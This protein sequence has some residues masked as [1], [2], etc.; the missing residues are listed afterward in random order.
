MQALRCDLCN[1][2]LVMDAS[3]E[4]A[5]CEYCGTKYLTDRLRAKIQEIKGTVKVEGPVE[6]VSG[7]AE[8]ERQFEKADAFLRLDDVTHAYQLLQE[9]EKN[10]PDDV[11]TWELYFKIWAK[12]PSERVLNFPI[13]SESYGSANAT[14]TISD[15]AKKVLA[16]P[17][18]QQ[19]L[20]TQIKAFMQTYGNS[21]RFAAEGE[22]RFSRWF[23]VLSPKGYINNTPPCNSIGNPTFF[24]LFQS[25]NFVQIANCPEFTQFVT[26]L[27]NQYAQGVYSGKIFPVVDQAGYFRTPIFMNPNDWSTVAPNTQNGSIIF[28]QNIAKIMK[29]HGYK[30]ENMIAD[31]RTIVGPWMMSRS[32]YSDSEDF[33]LINF[34]LSPNDYRKESGLCQHCG[35]TFNGMFNKAC[36][37]CGKPKDY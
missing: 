8:K 4:F 33:A 20:H 11:R 2:G 14:N 36:S 21:L 13:Y 5:T 16:F 9:L 25:S 22:Q 17:D 24:L 32:P 29:K 19:R 10:Y 6:F 15:Y 23:R 30:D 27:V 26:T 18:G 34:S 12:I 37:V 35:G 7:A 3:G 31:I 1:A 28:R